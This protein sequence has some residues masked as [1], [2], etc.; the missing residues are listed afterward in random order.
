M[1]LS[2]VLGQRFAEK[3]VCQKSSK[4]SRVLREVH[5]HGFGVTP[6]E[7]ER[8]QQRKQREGRSKVQ[9][10]P[11]RAEKNFFNIKEA[12]THLLD[13]RLEIL[14]QLKNALEEVICQA[15]LSHGA[16]QNSRCFSPARG[17]RVRHA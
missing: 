12:A 13:Q 5:A 1:Q 17:S 16:L 11:I 6:S 2:N 14:V 10:A 4:P 7:C 3:Y 8:W 15:I 9:S